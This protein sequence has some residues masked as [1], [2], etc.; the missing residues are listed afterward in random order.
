MKVRQGFVSN[1]SSSSFVVMIPTETEACPHCG[2]TNF[3]LFDLLS[4]LDRGY[5]DDTCVYCTE[6]SIDQLEFE[7]IYSSEE[8]CSQYD[9][10]INIIKNPPTGWEAQAI[11]INYHDKTANFLFESAKK[12]I[13]HKEEDLV[14]SGIEKAESF[15]RE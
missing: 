12:I 10:I 3:N 15:Y 5:D 4:P 7:K 9:R 1:S 8:E 6:D 14:V 2:R 11:Q 13:L